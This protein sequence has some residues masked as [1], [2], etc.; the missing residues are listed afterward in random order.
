MNLRNRLVS[1]SRTIPANRDAMHPAMLRMKIVNRFMLHASVI[2][3]RYRARLPLQ[4]HGMFFGND[5]TK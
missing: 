4:A 1:L 3:D 5:V 2:P